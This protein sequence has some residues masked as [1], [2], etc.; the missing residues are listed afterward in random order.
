MGF[1][2]DGAGTAEAPGTGVLAAFLALAAPDEGG[3]GGVPDERLTSAGHLASRL[4]LVRRRQRRRIPG[5]VHRGL[6]ACCPPAGAPPPASR[7][8]PGTRRCAPAARSRP[9]TAS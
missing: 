2:G 5:A 3:R 8:A 4:N 6:A 9:G 1:C 7:C